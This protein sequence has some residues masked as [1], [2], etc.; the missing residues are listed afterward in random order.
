MP[1]YRLSK[2]AEDD[3][4]RIYR[5]GIETFGQKQADI[6]FDALFEKFDSI[7][8]APSIYQAIDA[9]RPGYRRCVFGSN[10]IYYRS[11]N[12]GTVIA[13]ILGREDPILANI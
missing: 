6:Y 7:A 5:Y 8:Q 10:T 1:S 2:R 11:D 13:R 3:I 4:K 12:N 9:I